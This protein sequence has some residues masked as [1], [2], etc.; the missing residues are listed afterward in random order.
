[1]PQVM[2]YRASLFLYSHTLNMGMYS[3]A[4][5]Y[6]QAINGKWYHINYQ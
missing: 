1:M 5:H 6:L 2:A 4:W 3:K